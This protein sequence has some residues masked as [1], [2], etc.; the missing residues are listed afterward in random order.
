MIT[1]LNSESRKIGL[2][3]NKSKTEIM[4]SQNMVAPSIR[5]EHETVEQL[6]LSR[7]ACVY[8]RDTRER[9]EATKNHDT[10]KIRQIQQ[11]STKP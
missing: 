6:C 11:I 7:L 4:Y 8:D 3:M 1:E 10:V 5:V 2:K 9:T